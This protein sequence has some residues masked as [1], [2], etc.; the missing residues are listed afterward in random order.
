MSKI[1][2]CIVIRGSKN[3]TPED[4]VAEAIAPLLKQGFRVTSATTALA[5][6]S[7]WV[8][9]AKFGG[10]EIMPGSAKH[11]YYV[12]TVILEK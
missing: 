1:D 4:Q 7:T 12:T 11:V 9:G 8:E 6:H 2:T 10:Q 5:P 3:F